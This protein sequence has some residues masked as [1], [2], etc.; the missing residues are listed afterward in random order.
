MDKPVSQPAANDTSND[1]E[2]IGDLFRKHPA[3]FIAGGVAL[4]II[5]GALLPRGTGRRL[6]K[7]AVVLATTAGEAG[8]ALSR[9]AR[10]KAEDLGREGRDALERNAGA[11][12]RRAAEL[13]DNARTTGAK[14]VDQVVELASKVR[15]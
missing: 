10:D 6:A 1:Q 9:N 13:A 7:G 12:Q 4:G 5:A 3:A 11:A 8:L 15:S 2:S 14:L